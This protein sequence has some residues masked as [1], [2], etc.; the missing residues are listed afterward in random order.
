ML[1]IYTVNDCCDIKHLRESQVLAESDGCLK[2]LECN[3]KVLFEVL[4]LVKAGLNNA[5]ICSHYAGSYS[6]NE[7]D[8]FLKTLCAEKIICEVCTEEP[9]KTS[10]VLIGEGRIFDYIKEHPYG[11]RLIKRTLSTEMFLNTPVG[12]FE[13]V[14]IFAPSSASYKDFLDANK[15]FVSLSIPNIPIYFSGESYICGPF[16]FP[17]KTPCIECV[18]T[19]HVNALNRSN[20]KTVKLEDIEDLQLSSAVPYS[21]EWKQLEFLVELLWEDVVSAGKQCANFVFHKKELHFNANIKKGYTEK[22][23]HPITDCACCHGMN[24]HFRPFQ[25]NMTAPAIPAPI[26]KEQIKYQV[27]GLR[28]KTEAET[29]YLIETAIKKMGA[30][31]SIDL[32]ENN[33]FHEILPVFDSKLKT[34][35][36]NTTPFFLDGGTSHGKGITQQQAYFSAAFELFERL[37]ARYYGTETIIRATPREVSEYSID[38]SKI[39]SQVD[40]VDIVYD[41]FSPDD[42]VDWVWGKSLITNKERLI[43]ASNV[44]LTSAV[45]RGNYVPNGSSG[46]SAGADLKDAILQGLFEAIEHDAWMIGQANPFPLPLIDKD[47]VSNIKVKEIIRQ[48]Q[49]RGFEVYIRDY[50]TDLGI[51]VIRT[52]ITDPSNY[53]KYGFTG[54]GCSIDADLALERSIT[55]AVQGF[56]PTETEEPHEYGRI[57][58]VDAISS[59]DSLFGMFYFQRKDIEGVAALRS[60]SDFPSAIV[61]TVDEALEY[62]VK[63]LKCAMPDCDILFVDLTREEFGIPAVKIIITGD[64]QRLSEPLV[65]V[66]ERLYTFSKKMGYSQECPRYEELYLGPYQH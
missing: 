46:L 4:S 51:P 22:K 43:P 60:M 7:V 26:S 11:H 30:T 18:F 62:V 1:K 35:H 17:W 48:I 39:T 21:C 23:Y 61:S 28:S 49:N 27:G 31:I 5:E 32:V 34:A 56:L 59:R 19:H 3:H 9:V 10:V 63:K 37:S 33:I 58:M 45:F 40:N 15:K 13:D 25:K 8:T 65:T 66:S 14:A 36:K 12:A 16:V 57:H 20:V 64:I 41:K 47:S 54:F 52:W 24:K 42:P 55:E 50:T 38:L 29:K 6:Q 44:F 53:A 2:I